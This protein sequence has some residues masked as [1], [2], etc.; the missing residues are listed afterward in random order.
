MRISLIILIF[1][2]VLTAHAKTPDWLKKLRRIKPLQTTEAEVENILGK[3]TKRY[4][5]LGEYEAGD[6]EFSIYYSE[7]ECMPVMMTS[8]K[9]RKGVV[10]KFDFDPKKKIKFA[11]LGI[12]VSDWKKE[13]PG[14]D[15]WPPPITYSNPAQGIIYTVNWQGLLSF[16]EVY[17][18]N[19]LEKLECSE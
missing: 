17:P 10:I 12:D 8:Y 19:N 9:V 6:G 7:G 16:V 11:S 1:F 18:S 15:M 4:S 14:N 13:K 3:A 2:S 5:N